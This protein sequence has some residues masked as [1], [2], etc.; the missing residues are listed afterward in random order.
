M[1]LSE[2]CGDRIFLVIG[3]GSTFI[4]LS[5]ATWCSGD[6]EQGAHELGFARV[7][8]SDHSQIS[9][10][11]RGECFHMVCLFGPKSTV[12]SPKS[13]DRRTLDFGPGTLDFICWLTSKS[14]LV[15]E[16]GQDS[17]ARHVVLLRETDSSI[18]GITGLGYTGRS[19]SLEET[20]MLGA[21]RGVRQA[22]S[23]G[24][25]VAMLWLPYATL[26]QDLVPISSLTGGS[27]V[28]VVRNS[29]RA[30]VRVTPV[31]RPTRTKAQ[32]L[33]SV[34]KLNKQYVATSKQHREVAKVV[35]PSK[36][37]KNYKTLP[38]ADGSKLFAGVGDI[39]LAEQRSRQGYRI[40]PRRRRSRWQG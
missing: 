24:I 40:F 19:L 16:K 13:P 5:P 39:Y 22:F 34:A 3:D 33:E 8:V 36:L 9:N 28:F 6:V 35:D 38:A 31:A 15:P 37:P 32:Q 2:P 17:D 27:S 26:A 10:V 1:L 25:I 14:I 20:S 29:A 4:Y 12:Q 7:A 23:L 11:L 30:A 18:Y 21:S